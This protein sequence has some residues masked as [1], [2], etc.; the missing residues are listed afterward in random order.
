MPDELIKENEEVIETPEVEV[1]KPNRSDNRFKDLSEKVKTTAQERDE[2]A[3][4]LA[5]M[6]KENE[7]RKGFTKVASKYEGA[8]EYEDKILEKVNSGYDLEDATI[9]VMAKAGKLQNAPQQRSSPAG[10]SASTAIQSGDDKPVSE[11]TMAEKAEKIREW[12]RTNPGESL[13]TLQTLN[14]S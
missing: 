5:L 10:G 11:M 7:F 3:A 1:E 8:S 14:K 6:E 4:K 12:E 2:L 13:K 9:S